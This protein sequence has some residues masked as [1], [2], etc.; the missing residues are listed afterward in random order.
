MLCKISLSVRNN[1]TNDEHAF[2][3]IFGR[4]R[5]LCYFCSLLFYVIYVFFVMPSIAIPAI[6]TPYYQSRL[7]LVSGIFL[8]NIFRHEMSLLYLS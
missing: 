1:F 3:K 2:L 8:V 6:C 5:V 7:N 4:V